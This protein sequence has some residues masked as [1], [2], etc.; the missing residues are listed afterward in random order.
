MRSIYFLIQVI[1]LWAHKPGILC[2]LLCR[3][4]IVVHQ[5]KRW[6]HFILKTWYYT[7]PAPSKDFYLTVCIVS[8]FCCTVIFTISLTLC[9]KWLY[10][11]P[12]GSGEM[13]ASLWQVS[14]NYRIDGGIHTLSVAALS[15]LNA[16]EQIENGSIHGDLHDILSIKLHIHGFYFWNRGH[17]HTRSVVQSTR[18]SFT[19]LHFCVGFD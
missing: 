6:V 3:K 19:L 9:Y 15:P 13:Y 4:R 5:P 17:N 18:G 12:F 10:T 1:P 16:R 7:C 2:C 8:L 11:E 14:V